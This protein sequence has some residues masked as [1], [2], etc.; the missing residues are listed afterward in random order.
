M[1]YPDLR[2]YTD[3]RDYR[4]NRG[5]KNNSCTQKINLDNAFRELWEQHIMWTRSFLVSNIKSLDD[6]KY[7][8]SRL[9]RNPSDFAKILKIYYGKDNALK[10]QRL[11]EEHL[12]LAADLV[13]Q[14]KA[15][16][17]EA[18]K[19]TETKWYANA[20]SIASF[21][22]S[23]NLFWSKQEWQKLLY[24]HLNLLKQEVADIIGDIY[25]AAIDI[26]DQIEDDALEMADYMAAGISNQ[27]PM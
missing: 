25:P 13:N 10:F 3:I 20:D 19:E 26:Y 22:A 6:L 5:K 9:L 23:L 12:M 16:N 4:N 18:A 17:M 7:V 11:L 14:V 15:G 24:A 8:T 2:D 27:F 1:D 21:L